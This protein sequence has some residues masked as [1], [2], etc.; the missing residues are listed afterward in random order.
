[1]MSPKKCEVNDLSNPFEISI[2]Y[3]WGFAASLWYLLRKNGILSR[4]K[5]FLGFCEELNAISLS[6]NWEAFFLLHVPPHATERVVPK[7]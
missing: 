3:F 2:N 6:S 5:L 1:M 4:S 7:E